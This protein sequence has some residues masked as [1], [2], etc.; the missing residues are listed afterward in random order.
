MKV[1]IILLLLAILGITAACA[2]PITYLP[3]A[4]PT[5]VVVFVDLTPTP[6]GRSCTVTTGEPNGAIN[7]RAGPGL[8]R[9]V[10]GI[11]SEGEQLTIAN[12]GNYAGWEMVTTPGEL[13]GFIE[14]ARWC[15]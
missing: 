2:A 8:D 7:L 9:P 1:T 6:A 10:I 3:E 4:S 5:P 13:V 14:T 12:A 11:V 15:K